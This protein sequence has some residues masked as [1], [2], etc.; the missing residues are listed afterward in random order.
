MSK[1][2]SVFV[3]FTGRL[4]RS[5][6]KGKGGGGRG[7]EIQR[8]TK[9]GSVQTMFIYVPS[10]HLSMFVTTK[11]HMSKQVQRKD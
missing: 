11:L 4:R 7:E 9:K 10:P 6:L 1:I 8:K 5:K 2:I 3:T